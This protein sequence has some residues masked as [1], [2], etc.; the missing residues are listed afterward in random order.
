MTWALASFF[1][2]KQH[3]DIKIHDEIVTS[4]KES[5]F[6]YSPAKKRRG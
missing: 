5:W 3:A 4:P 6:V 1:K 2:R